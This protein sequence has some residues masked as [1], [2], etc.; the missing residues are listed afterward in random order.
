MW[1][2]CLINQQLNGFAKTACFGFGLTGSFGVGYVSYRALTNYLERPTQPD[3][4]YKK[5]S[6]LVNR[7][8]FEDRLLSQNEE[9]NYDRPFAIHPYLRTQ[10][11]D[12]DFERWRHFMCKMKSEY[13]AR[14]GPYYV[15]MIVS[16]S[17]TGLATIASGLTGY[18]TYHV[19]HSLYNEF[20]AETR[21]CH[22]IRKGVKATL[23]FSMLGLT[24]ATFLITMRDT[25]HEVL[26]IYD[27]IHRQ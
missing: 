7:P 12:L 4:A 19:A 6:Y 14:L 20:R 17:G 11:I 1:S 24:G 27:R 22:L 26:N 15:D 5:S 8:T 9:L 25:A 13:R 23:I 18:L 10:L 2:R 21:C 16:A 3:Y